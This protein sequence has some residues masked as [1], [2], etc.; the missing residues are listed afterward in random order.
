MLDVLVL[1]HLGLVER[2]VKVGG[3]VVLVRDTD[4]D[5]LYEWSGANSFYS[6]SSQPT[7]ESPMNV[8]SPSSQSWAA[9]LSADGQTERH[10]EPQ[11]QAHKHP[12]SR[13]RTS[14]EEFQ[15]F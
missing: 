11:F 3:I 8:F 13:D 14:E 2:L 5:E 10:L 6:E 4:P 1:V 12:S 7:I 15:W 9:R